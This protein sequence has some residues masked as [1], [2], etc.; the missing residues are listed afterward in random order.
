MSEALPLRDIIAFEPGWWPPAPIWW[1]GALILGFVIYTLARWLINYFRHEHFYLKRSAFKELE[2]IEKHVALNDQQLATK[3]SALLKRVALQRFPEQRLAQ[4]NGQSWLAFLDS[5]VPG[6]AFSSV[7][8]APLND[9]QYQSTA[10]IDRRA[11][12]AAAHAWLKAL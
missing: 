12:F 9:A 4:L 10:K 6:S 5:A 3:V 1:F 11:L 8:G 7:G 2:Q